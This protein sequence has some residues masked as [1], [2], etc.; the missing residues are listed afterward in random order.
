M[1]ILPLDLVV[2]RWRPGE[3]HLNARGAWLGA[4]GQPQVSRVHGPAVHSQ[5]GPVQKDTSQPPTAW[6]LE[7]L[8]PTFKRELDSS[9]KEMNTVQHL[10]G[11][12]GSEDVVMS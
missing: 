11:L 5:P 10:R 9:L 2:L 4:S 12:D 7:P 1:G 3:D 6:H 8:A